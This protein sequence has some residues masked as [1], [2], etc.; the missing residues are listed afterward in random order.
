V[1]V[2]INLVWVLAALGVVLAVVFALQVPELKRY[3]KM[4][5]M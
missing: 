2:Q 5:T 1:K 4:E 3:I